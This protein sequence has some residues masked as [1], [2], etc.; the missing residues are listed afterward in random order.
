MQAKNIMKTSKNEACPKNMAWLEDGIYV[1]SPQ[2]C[3]RT[4]ASKEE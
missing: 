3:Y 4:L 2:G 1:F